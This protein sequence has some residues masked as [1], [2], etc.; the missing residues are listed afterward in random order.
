MAFSA[1]GK[2]SVAFLEHRWGVSDRMALSLKEE[3][4]FTSGLELTETSL[5]SLWISPQDAFKEM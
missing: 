4:I 2:H 1:S 5:D 3:E